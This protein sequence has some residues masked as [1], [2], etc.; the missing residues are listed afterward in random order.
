MYKI[1][2]YIVKDVVLF[3]RIIVMY[4]EEKKNKEKVYYCFVIIIKL[5]KRRKKISIWI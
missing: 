3:I 2:M 5:D 4:L 1:I